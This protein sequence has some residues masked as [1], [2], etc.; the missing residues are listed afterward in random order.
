[1]KTLKI[2]EKFLFVSEKD[3]LGSF[4]AL[5]GKKNLNQ[6]QYC[7]KQPSLQISK[8][9][10]YFNKKLSNFPKVQG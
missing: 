8:V 1:M 10:I 7:A 6:D 4:D 2:I 9:A 3:R 5:A